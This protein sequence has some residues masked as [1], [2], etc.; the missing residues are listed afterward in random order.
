MNLSAPFIAR[1]VATTL[2]TI[3]LALAGMV[4]FTG[5]TWLAPLFV[6][7]YLVY[8]R[9]ELKQTDSHEVALPEP[10][11]LDPKA[12][13]P[14]LGKVLLQ[15]LVA[16]GVV[17]L[18]AQLFVQLC[19]ADGI[20]AAAE[21]HVLVAVDRRVDLNLQR[22]QASRRRGSAGGGVRRGSGMTLDRKSNVRRS[23][24]SVARTGQSSSSAASSTRR[25]IRSR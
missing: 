20:Q 14:A 15:T 8:V 18:A 7:V 11:K 24:V 25:C 6:L 13:I 16:L 21:Q 4:A 12:E 17:A 10:L 19:V 9:R 23:A 22:H 1:P 5:K 3:G 2:L